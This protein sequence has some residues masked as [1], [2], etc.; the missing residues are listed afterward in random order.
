MNPA[1]N[2]AVEPAPFDKAINAIAREMMDSA[3]MRSRIRRCTS[4]HDVTLVA[5]VHRFRE[6][7][8]EGYS[9]QGVARVCMLMSGMRSGTKSDLGSWIASTWGVGKADT[10]TRATADVRLS[11]IVRN[12]SPDLFLKALRTLA[13]R[14]EGRIPAVAAAKAI[15]AWE[16]PATMKSA[17]ERLVGEYAAATSGK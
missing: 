9:V 2:I 7:L 12:S 8:G 11:T 6:R 13:E 3:K 17:A 10:D 4:L 14:A 1:E 5:E 16:S 15:L